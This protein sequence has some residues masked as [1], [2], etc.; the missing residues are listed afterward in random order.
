MHNAQRS[1]AQGALAFCLLRTHLQGMSS[2]QRRRD[3]GV[4]PQTAWHRAH[5]IREAGHNA[6][7]RCGGP[8]AAAAIYV[9]GKAQNK[10]GARRLRAGRGPVG[11]TAVVGV[12][13]RPTG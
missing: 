7:G 13:D 1:L 2:L 6:T 4:T 3:L 10:H 12:K 11:K 9:G 5:R 8:V